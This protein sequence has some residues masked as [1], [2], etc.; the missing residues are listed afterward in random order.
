MKKI[1]VLLLFVCISFSLYGQWE[2]RQSF[3]VRVVAGTSTLRG[4]DTYKELPADLIED[5]AVHNRFSWDVGLSFRTDFANDFIFWTGMS[6]GMAGANLDGVYRKEEN[7]TIKVNSIFKSSWMLNANFGR[8]AYVTKDFGFIVALG[9]YFDFDIP[10][11]TLWDYEKPSV[12]NG[13]D[14]KF[15]VCDLGAMLTAGIEYKGF[16][17]AYVPQFGFIDL[18]SNKSKIHHRANKIALTWFFYY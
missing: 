2:Y 4:L 9:L 12:I 16:Q 10:E 6:F 13:S 7:R 5:M 1:S 18:S 8:K 14:A 11:A 3:G 17:L 15:K